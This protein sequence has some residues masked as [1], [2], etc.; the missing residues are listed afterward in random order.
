MPKEPE[1]PTTD[2]PSSG[3][4]LRDAANVG[5][6]I[7]G[8]AIM[9]L[10]LVRTDPPGSMVPGRYMEMS[11]VPFDAEVC[12]ALPA[13][14]RAVLISMVYSPHKQAWI[15]HAAD[16]FARRCKNVRLQLTARESMAAVDAFLDGDEPLPTV[17]SP[18]TSRAV[19][20]LEQR[21]GERSKESLVHGQTSLLRSPLILMVWEDRGDVLE[22]VLGSD[23]SDEGTWMK[24]A[25]PSIPRST[26][27]AASLSLEPARSAATRGARGRWATWAGDAVA[28]PDNPRAL[29]TRKRREE[30]EKEKAARHLP[31]RD[32][33]ERWGQVKLVHAMP[34]RSDAGLDALYLMAYDYLVPPSERPGAG[35]QPPADPRARLARNGP[36]AGSEHLGRSFE[37]RLAEKKEALLGWLRRC[38]ADLEEPP[39]STSQL[40]SSMFD[41]GPTQYDGV[42]TYENLTFPILDRIDNHESDLKTVSILYPSTTL[43]SDHPVVLLRPETP[44]AEAA[45]KKWIQFLGSQEMQ[46]KAI[47]Y[48]FRPADPGMRVGDENDEKNPFLR[49]RRYGIK[50]SPALTEPPLLE[51]KSVHEILELWKEATGRN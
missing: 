38:E 12:G 40:A 33:L 23:E 21:W 25:C 29:L 46:R 15:E 17:W 50:P 43:V 19:H 49:M 22:A 5:A 1:E 42:M 35:D 18:T 44:E 26:A 31:S 48:G 47:E 11:V 16:A 39:Q 28:P 3:T 32:E 37:G 41:L 14:G 20:Y 8:I 45:A 51:G 9:G 2:Q 13:D 24:V 34:S 6:T 10:L 27:A 7:G 36:I 4:L 30:Q